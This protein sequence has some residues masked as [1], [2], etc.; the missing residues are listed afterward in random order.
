MQYTL[1]DKATKELNDL[2]ILREK[3]P[4][5]VV[6]LSKL[7]DK[8]KE[9]KITQQLSKELLAFFKRENLLSGLYLG[10]LSGFAITKKLFLKA[11][12]IFEKYIL[13][14]KYDSIANRL[15]QL[16]EMVELLNGHLEFI[17]QVSRENL[18]NSFQ[19]PTKLYQCFTPELAESIHSCII[20]A[21]LER[22]TVRG[23]LKRRF[24]ETQE[25]GM[26]YL[27]NLAKEILGADE[28]FAFALLLPFEQVATSL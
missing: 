7:I 26:I 17:K 6:N 18:R 9:K 4:S 11:K 27:D 3:L 12:P 10:S 16:H 13:R 23:K 2:V 5:V 22:R 28:L 15:S 1:S 21:E 25:Y 19:M 14:E 20:N 8:T 24:L